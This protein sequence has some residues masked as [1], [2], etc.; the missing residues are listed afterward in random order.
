[1]IDE[2]EPAPH[3]GEALLYDYFKHLTS[4]CLISLGG[5]LALADKVQGRGAM[6]VIGALGVIGIAALLSFSGAGEIVEARCKGKPLARHLDWY[7]IASPAL[8]SIGLGMFLYIFLGTMK[9]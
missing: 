4:L 9:P 2:D 1:M 6:L 8:L 5:V 3:Q 7:R